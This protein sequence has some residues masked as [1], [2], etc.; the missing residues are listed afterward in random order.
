MRCYGTRIFTNLYG[1]IFITL[2]PP[3]HYRSISIKYSSREYKGLRSKASSSRHAA[4]LPLTQKRKEK[5]CAYETHLDKTSGLAPGSSH[6]FLSL[7][8]T[9]FIQMGFNSRIQQVYRAADGVCRV[10]VR[11]DYHE[12]LNTRGSLSYRIF[13]AAY[14]LMTIPGRFFQTKPGKCTTSQNV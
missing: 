6:I 7:R 5:Y 12:K 1:Y 10:L 14:S 11:V 8:L 13:Q 2:A 3:K 9:N 4:K